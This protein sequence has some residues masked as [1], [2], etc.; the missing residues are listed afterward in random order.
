MGSRG[1]FGR[2]GLNRM[3]VLIMGW[4]GMELDAMRRDDDFVVTWYFIL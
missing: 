4:G 2:M 1:C 3:V